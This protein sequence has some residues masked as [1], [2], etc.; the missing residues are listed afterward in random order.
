MAEPFASDKGRLY[1]ATLNRGKLAELVAMLSAG[2]KTAFDA[3]LASEL[4][5]AIDWDESGDTF[6]ANALIKAQA[7][8][9]RLKAPAAVL[10]DDSGLV[11]EALGGAPGVI[12]ARYGGPEATAA[13]NVAKLLKEMHGVPAGK[14][15]AK[16][17]CTLCFI[18]AQGNTSFHVGECHGQIATAPRGAAGFGYDPVFIVDGGRLTMAELPEEKKNAVSHRRRA[19]DLWQASL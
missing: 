17:V 2:G 19:F 15:Q 6:A 10:A 18:D 4:D 11:V 14:R 5:P 3:R 16:F 7:V 12:S 9:R 1:L 8:K 13:D